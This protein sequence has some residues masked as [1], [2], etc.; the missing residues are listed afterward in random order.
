MV[1]AECGLGRKGCDHA[2]QAMEE[3]STMSY[4]QKIPL[5]MMARYTR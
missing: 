3:R 5:G 4:L 1:G 2:G